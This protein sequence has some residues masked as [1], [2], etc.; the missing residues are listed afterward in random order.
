MG[1]LRCNTWRSKHETWPKLH[2][3]RK[4]IGVLCKVSILHVLFLDI[5]FHQFHC[6]SLSLAQDLKLLLPGSPHAGRLCNAINKKCLDP[7]AV[8]SVSVVLKPSFGD[9]SSSIVQKIGRSFSGKLQIS[10]AESVMLSRHSPT[11]P[12]N[13][14]VHELI[15]QSQTNSH[16]SLSTLA[17][18]I[19]T[20][21]KTLA[22]KS[23]SWAFVRFKWNF[24][25]KDW[26]SPLNWCKKARP[27]QKKTWS[28][29]SLQLFDPK[30]TMK[31]Q[32]ADLQNL[33]LP[34]SGEATERI[35]L[36]HSAARATARCPRR[37][38]VTSNVTW[39]SGAYPSEIMWRFI[40]SIPFEGCSGSSSK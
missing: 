33:R 4:F 38:A 26:I 35:S 31:I 10:G 37:A 28:V 1:C 9:P 8:R 11:F 29:S 5:F 24:E 19:N 30:I 7:T 39:A 22:S 2:H 20:Y 25:Q 23:W 18:F 6:F 21:K 13:A 36:S 15:G 12:Q 17:P 34:E 16:P 14:E 40:G 3:S 27:H 32:P